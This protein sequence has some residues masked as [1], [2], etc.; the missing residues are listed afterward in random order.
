M[1]FVDHS[2]DQQKY[3]EWD[4][5][6]STLKSSPVDRTAPQK[7]KVSFDWKADD[8]ALKLPTVQAAF[9]LDS[10]SPFLNSSIQTGQCGGSVV[11]WEVDFPVVGGIGYPHASS[12]QSHLATPFHSGLRID[13]P[14]TRLFDR[15]GMLYPGA[16]GWQFLSYYD[17]SD[18][19]FYYAAHDDQGYMKRFRHDPNGLSLT[20]CY[21]HQP[22][23]KGT[24]AAAYKQPYP[25]LFGPYKGDWYEATQFYRQF[26]VQTQWFPK[27]TLAENSRL[28]E[29]FK[30]YPLS[31]RIFTGN[32][33]QRI[34]QFTKKNLDLINQLKLPTTLVQ[35]YGWNDSKPHMVGRP[36]QYPDP[37]FL[38][39]FPLFEK[40]NAHVMPYTCALLWDVR[41]EAYKTL[42]GQK[43]A[44]RD[45]NGEIVMARYG[46]QPLAMISPSHPIY[47]D[48]MV[49]VFQK[50]LDAV[51]AKALYFDMWGTA[52][53]GH[54]RAEGEPWG[55]NG[56]TVGMRELGKKV[57]SVGLSKNPQF[58]MAMEGN[59]DCYLDIADTYILF[60]ANLPIRMAL[61]G[62]YVRPFGDKSCQWRDDIFELFEPASLLAWGVPIGRVFEFNLYKDGQL[63]P[64]MIAY[65]QKLASYRL[66]AVPWL[67]YGKMLRPVRLY[68]ISPKEPDGLMPADTI[69]NAVWKAPDGSVA[70]VFANSR[71]SV[72]QTSFKYTLKCADYG[73][74]SDGSWTLYR[75]TPKDSQNSYKPAYE[76]VFPIKQ[77][78]LSRTEHLP[79]ADVLILVARP[80]LK[81]DF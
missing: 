25:C 47:Q 54:Y 63:D 36:E 64:K 53:G 14:G 78:L 68:D 11:F 79:G 62:D 21:T 7:V 73:I 9:V 13:S 43:A 2:A 31:I 15:D 16:A 27:K 4:G 70:F 77:P 61:Y 35:W 45:L 65:F 57:K 66:V 28:P 19:A 32:K 20:L 22:E 30:E 3:F 46:G 81:R 10:E 34:S 80:N 18:S 40:R 39:A 5:S 74:P 26:L 58:V 44:M 56:R 50:I 29:W 33:G 1:R 24:T 69:P 51:D 76:T 72:Q 8:D 55:G 49:S 37:E 17:D 12:W 23:G 60:S 52:S 6:E 48:Y 38:K 71:Y 41:N 75:L 67:C 59:A 42:Q